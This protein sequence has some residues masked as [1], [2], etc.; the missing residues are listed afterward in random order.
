MSKLIKIYQ[1]IIRVIK[2]EYIKKSN[3]KKRIVLKQK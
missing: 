3:K 2:I 1:N